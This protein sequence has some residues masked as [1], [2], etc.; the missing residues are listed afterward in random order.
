MPQCILQINSSQMTQTKLLK[1]KCTGLPTKA[2][3]DHVVGPNAKT[4][5]NDMVNLS[6][7]VRQLR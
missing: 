3:T 5:G 2:G 6:K 7:E 4:D 1:F